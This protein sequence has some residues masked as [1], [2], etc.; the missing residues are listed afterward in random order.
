MIYKQQHLHSTWVY[1]PSDSQLPSCDLT[2]C[3]SSLDSG[4]C[5]EKQGL[6]RGHVK[7]LKP[8]TI[9]LSQCLLLLPCAALQH[10]LKQGSTSLSLRCL[11]SR[12]GSSSSLLSSCVVQTVWLPITEAW[13]ELASVKGETQF[14][15]PNHWKGIGSGVQRTMNWGSLV[16]L[17]LAMWVYLGVF[18]CQI[19][20]Q[21]HL[22]MCVKW[23]CLWF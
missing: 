14:T 21:C 3:S 8:P 15:Q 17:G 4:I 7:S 1:C 16:L 11:S 19:P 2:G 10:W 20:D 13:P 22:L 6:A 12:A 5:T 18:R 9:H 23:G